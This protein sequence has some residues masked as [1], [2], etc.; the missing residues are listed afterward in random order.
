MSKTRFKTKVI[1]QEV[2]T[3]EEFEKLEVY[4]RGMRGYVEQ[5]DV[6]EDVMKVTYRI[7]QAI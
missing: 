5:I 3:I 7:Q 1:T 6:K 4:A 2:S